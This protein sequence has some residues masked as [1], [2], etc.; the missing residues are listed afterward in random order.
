FSGHGARVNDQDFL[1]PLD[2]NPLNV[3]ATAIPLERLQ[4]KLSSK[5]PRSVIAFFD[6]CRNEV[7]PPARAGSRAGGRHLLA[8]AFRS[9]PPP[10]KIAYRRDDPLDHAP[11]DLSAVLYSCGPTETSYDSGELGESVFTYFLLEG[12][13]G[14][15]AAVD[16]AQD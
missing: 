4:G 10:V 2:V 1:C 14:D 7:V 5:R 3:D 11:G 15:P 8:A 6:I 9:H 12:L 13:R 16:Q